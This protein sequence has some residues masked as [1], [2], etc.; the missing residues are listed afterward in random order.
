[1]VTIVLHLLVRLRIVMLMFRTVF[2]VLVLGALCVRCRQL[3][4]MLRF[5]F[6]VLHCLLWCCVRVVFAFLSVVPFVLCI[7]CTFVAAAAALDKIM[8]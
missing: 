3:G 4:H 7:V 8:G 5:W 2:L 1:M 6:L